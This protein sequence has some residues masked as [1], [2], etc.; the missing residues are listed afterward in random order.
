[1]KNLFHKPVFLAVAFLVVI[2]FGV[3][4][5][6]YA[7]GYPAWITMLAGIL[8]G[9][10]LLIVLKLVLTWIAPFAKKIPITLVTTV[11]G[12]FLALYIMRMY[13]FGWPS[14]LFYGLALFG[15]VCLLLLT[16]GVW[17]IVRKK[18]A[19]KGTVLVILGVALGVLGFMD[20]MLWMV[21]LM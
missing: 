12:G 14:I 5:Y 20:S 17:Q 2:L 4:G 10:L 13:A 8:I 16:F 9:I 19:K 15:F 1:M 18:N 11:L 3:A 6:H 7:I 21:I